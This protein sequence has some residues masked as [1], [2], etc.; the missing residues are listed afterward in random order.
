MG[1]H[2][3]IIPDGNRRWCRNNNKQLSNLPDVHIEKI[4]SLDL[5]LF[6]NLGHIRELSLYVLSME[7][8]KKR[9]HAD[10]NIVYDTIK[11]L[12]L[13]LYN[14][15]AKDVQFRFI[16]DIEIL[17]EDVKEIIRAMRNI[18]VN[19]PALVVNIAIGYDPIG[20]AHDV[21]HKTGSRSTFEQSPIDVVIRTSGEQRSSGF[22]PLHT[23][24]S[25]WIYEPKLFPDFTLSDLDRCIG[26]FFQRER[27]FG[28]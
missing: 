1:V 23:L 3:G 16:G 2:V 21:I 28:G 14:E 26:E 11:R 15:L 27:R 10:L 9:K 6:K 22:F 20:D 25:E 17:P 24:Y 8:I 19:Q 7:N 13:S 18:S 4:M 5:T 12:Y